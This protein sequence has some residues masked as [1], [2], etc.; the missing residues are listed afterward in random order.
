MTSDGAPCANPPGCSVDHQAPGP[1]PA[2]A[3]GWV[4]AAARSAGDPLIGRGV[5]ISA[6]AERQLEALAASRPEHTADI[7]AAVERLARHGV[8]SDEDTE[9]PGS[10]PFGQ[11]V[12]V[13]AGDARLLVADDGWGTLT[14]VGVVLRPPGSVVAPSH[15]LT[16][17]DGSPTPEAFLP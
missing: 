6:Q 14:V 13:R 4:S 17:P 8:D 1:A 3:A 12:R 10:S 5:E 16:G 11:L 7:E 9:V 2:A 15:T